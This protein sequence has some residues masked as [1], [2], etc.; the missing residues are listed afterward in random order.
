MTKQKPTSNKRMTEI[1]FKTI[2][3]K[4]DIFEE[5]VER[6]FAC[7]DTNDMNGMSSA[8]GYCFFCMGHGDVEFLFDII[9]YLKQCEIE[10]HKE[11]EE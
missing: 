5:D 3:D 10:Q 2:A 4:Y 1:T 6:I 11:K 8:I 9:C 7:Y